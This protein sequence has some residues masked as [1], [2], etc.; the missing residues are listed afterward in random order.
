MRILHPFDPTGTAS[1]SLDRAQAE[2]PQDDER[3]RLRE[4][5][6]Y[7]RDD[8]PERGAVQILRA[9]PKNEATECVRGSD[10]RYS[11][12][13]VPPPLRRRDQA[14]PLRTDHPENFR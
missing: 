13:R 7:A 9:M 11:L 5:A 12:H 4:T 8:P 3:R 2:G 10:D 1:R 14:N 6:P